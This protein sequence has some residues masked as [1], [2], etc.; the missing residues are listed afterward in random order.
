MWKFLE[1]WKTRVY[2]LA[3]ASLET[4]QPKKTA[5]CSIRRRFNAQEK[6]YA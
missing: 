6:R 5:K 3:P 1:M 4:D 2:F